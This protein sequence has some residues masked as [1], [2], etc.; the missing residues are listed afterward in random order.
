MVF[1]TEA[2][3]DFSYTVS[4]GTPGISKQQQQQQQPYVQITRYLALGAAVST[5]APCF[6]S[7]SIKCALGGEVCYLPL[8]HFSARRYASV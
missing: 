4:L 6:S 1:G 8:R 2:S 3:F 5:L 7:T